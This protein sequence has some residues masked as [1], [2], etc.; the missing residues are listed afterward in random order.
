MLEGQ[1][2]KQGPKQHAA[3]KA[4]KLVQGAPSD[5]AWLHL[6]QRMTAAHPHCLRPSARTP[7]RT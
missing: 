6:Q 5:A 1:H 3:V 4:C 2:P 7:T